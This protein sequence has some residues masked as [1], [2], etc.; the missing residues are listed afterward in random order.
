MIIIKPKEKCCWSLKL[1]LAFQG[2]LKSSLDSTFLHGTEQ[3]WWNEENFCDKLHPER[4]WGGSA[5]LCHCEG[6]WLP[7]QAPAQT[8]WMQ[9]PLLCLEL[10]PATVTLA[11]LGNE[12][13]KDKDGSKGWGSSSAA[14]EH[15]RFLCVH[16]LSCWCFTR[17]SANTFAFRNVGRSAEFR[18]YPGLGPAVLWTGEVPGLGKRGCVPMSYASTNLGGACGEEGRLGDQPHVAPE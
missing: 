14:C 15:K 2:G 3:L 10:T 17:I 12:S 13:P 4:W 11:P 18:D 8:C 7:M 9:P 1:V 16:I 6:S 5:P